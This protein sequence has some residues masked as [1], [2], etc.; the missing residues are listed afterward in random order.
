MSGTVLR[1]SHF[2]NRVPGLNVF[3]VV[4]DKEGKVLPQ[5]LGGSL[6]AAQYCRHKVDKAVHHD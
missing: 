1:R 6:T 2:G 3:S 4:S 5:Q